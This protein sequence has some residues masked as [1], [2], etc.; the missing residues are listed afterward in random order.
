MLW[1]YIGE[2]YTQFTGRSFE[3]YFQDRLMESGQYTTI[4]NWWE[5]SG[6]NEIDVVALNEF[7]HTGLIGEMKR[8]PE[9]LSMIELRDK[10]AVL[11]RCQFGRY[12]LD[13]KGFSLKD[14]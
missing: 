11:P 5:R 14:M 6:K 9:R 7:N 2:Q 8:N 10:A 13:Y 12:K 4:G 1:K 3:R